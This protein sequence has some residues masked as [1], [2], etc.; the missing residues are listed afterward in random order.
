MSA[1]AAVLLGAGVVAGVTGAWSPCGFSMVETLA[2]HG[3][4]GRLRT[5]LIACVTFTVGA[6]AG[7]VVTFGGLALI[8]QLVGAGGTAAA[9][10]AA[11]VAVAAALGEVRG[12]RIVPQ[13]R[14]Q[15]PEPWR[16]VLPVPLAAGLYGVLLGLGFTTFILSFAVW[17]LA[18]VS[19]ALGDPALGAVIGLGFGAG[20]ALPVIALAPAAGTEVGAGA[21]AAMAE[22]PA[23]LR[24]L[25]A[26]DALAL[27]GCAAA[28]GAAPAEA[29]S[30]ELISDNAA[31]PVAGGGV[32]AWQQPGGPGIVLRGGRVDAL[33]GRDPAIGGSL[34]GWREPARIVLADAATLA[35][36][37]AIDS[38]D[39]GAFALSERWLAWR[40]ARPGG[41]DVLYVRGLSPGSDPTPRQLAAVRSPRE[42]GRPAVSG[43]RV[44]FH[45]AG[46]GGSAIYGVDLPAGAPRAL[47]RRAGAQLTNPAVLGDEL[48]YVRAT[49][50]R[51]QLVVGAVGRRRSDRVLY[52][53]PPTNRRDVER[54]PGRERHNRRPLPPRAAPGTSTTLWTTALDEGYAYFT[55]LRVRRNGERRSSLLRVRRG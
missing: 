9:T 22:R 34:I 10:L 35:P 41:G 26:A 43:D 21:A 39:A 32:V 46:R 7:G 3:Y 40:V 49:A 51:Q 27:V 45:V 23:I 44:V 29:A 13:V 5:T 15:V 18:A 28:I 16:R 6:L 53:M 14:R 54:G 8:G 48:L 24:G 47:R 30:A 37:T 20:R 11:V 17:A 1:L 42:I 2:P 33:P 31:N 50:T 25:R 36:R 12:A 52:G 55:R 4:A 19:V 38:T